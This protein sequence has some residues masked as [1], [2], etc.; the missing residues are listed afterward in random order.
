M[1][2][3]GRSLGIAVAASALRHRLGPT[4]W[5]VLETL[6]AR[7][8]GTAPS[9]EAVATTRIL[10]AELG[11]SKDTVARALGALR[12]AGLVE[13]SQ[14]RAAEGTFASARYRILVPDC[15]TFL[16]IDLL[17]AAPVRTVDAKHRAARPTGS[18]LALS[19]D[20]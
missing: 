3:E 4:A 18:Q 2:T 9:C 1:R 7:S 12:R 16:D 15:I 14:D 8:T 20:S 19:L 10:A 6:L 11:L 5:A 17:D 13:A